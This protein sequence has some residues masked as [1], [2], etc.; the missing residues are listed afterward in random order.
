LLTFIVHV[1]VTAVAFWCVS[2]LLSGWKIKTPQTALVIAIMYALLMAVAWH[3]LRLLAVLI[4]LQVS[5]FAHWVIGLIVG[6]VAAMILSFMATVLVVV[7]V[8][9]ALDDF[10]VGG[11]VDLVMGC[12]LLS[13]IQMILRWFLGLSMI[14]LW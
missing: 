11:K 9:Y 6:Y 8:D 2:R 12:V 3:W 5:M 4:G 14:R 10:S 7:V 1:L 13:A